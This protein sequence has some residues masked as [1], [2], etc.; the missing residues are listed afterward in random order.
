MSQPRDPSVSVIIPAINERD[1]I[2]AAVQSAHRFG[3]D[4]IIVVDGGSTDETLDIA[5]R[6]PC[7]T[8]ISAPGRALQMNRG[9]NAATGQILMFL[10]ADCRLPADAA[11]LLRRAAGENGEFFGGFHQRIQ[12]PRPIFRLIERGN[13]WRARNRRLVYGDQGLFVSRPLWNRLGPFPEV[14]LME[15]YLLSR[16]M[17]KAVRP[18]VLGAR[19]QVSARRWQQRGAIRQTLTNWSI[20]TRYYLGWDLDRLARDYRRHDQ[21]HP[22]RSPTAD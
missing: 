19:L 17:G 18:I 13:A 8:V 9:A 11:G 3:A 21:T 2:E 1:S 5:E 12:D 10:H 16:R 15:D 4:E 20:V 22:P 6:L 7:R 14:P